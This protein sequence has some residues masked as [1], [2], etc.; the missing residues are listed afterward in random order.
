VDANAAIQSFNFICYTFNSI[1]N[2][3]LFQHQHFLNADQICGWE[4]IKRGRG[5]K[6]RE[7]E[8][9]AKETG[10]S[11]ERG[12]E[13][14]RERER[15]KE[16]M[17]EESR[18]RDEEGGKEREEGEEGGRGRGEEGGG[19][20]RGGKKG[21]RTFYKQQLLLCCNL[22]L[23]SP[24]QHVSCIHQVLLGSQQPF[25][26]L[27]GQDLKTITNCIPFLSMKEKLTN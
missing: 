6:E 16:R 24:V 5:E 12:G 17:V 4:E 26:S 2:L 1:S 20:G 8:E 11:K 9:G 15:R 3:L 23:T 10:R 13:K 14:E 22:Q 19:R 18:R 21:Q 27:C 25:T 7:E